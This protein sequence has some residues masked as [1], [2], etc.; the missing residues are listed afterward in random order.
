[1]T[2]EQDDIVVGLTCSSDDT[3]AMRNWLLLP[4]K[5]KKIGSFSLRD[6]GT[7]KTRC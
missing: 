5:I 4:K 7:L 3:D 2:Y 1:M 6:E